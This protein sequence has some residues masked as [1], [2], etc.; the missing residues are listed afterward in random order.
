MAMVLER[1]FNQFQTRKVRESLSHL[2]DCYALVL[3]ILQDGSAVNVSYQTAV[4][5]SYRFHLRT[6][7]VGYNGGV[8]PDGIYWAVRQ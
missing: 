5:F 4:F 8:P 7:L 2:R 3:Y 6:Y 1:L